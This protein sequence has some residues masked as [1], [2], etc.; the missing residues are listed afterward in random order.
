MHHTAATSSPTNQRWTVLSLVEWSTNHLIEHGFDEARLHAELLLAHV[1][2]CTRLQLYMNFD[3]PLTADELCM[4]R[5]LFKR[6]LTHEP[7]QYITG[8]TEFMGLPISVNSNVLIPRP[9]TEQLVEHAISI[10]NVMEKESVDVLDIGTGSGNIAIALAKLTSKAR[11]TS[12]EVSA[13]ALSLAQQNIERNAVKNVSL[14]L[15]DVFAEFLPDRIFDVMVSNPPY[16]SVTE[17]GTLDP[18]VRDFEPRLATTDG[19]DGYRFIRRICDVA[20]R[21]LHEGGSLLME[22]AHN[23]SGQAIT[24]AEMAGFANARVLADYSGHSRIIVVEK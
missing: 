16:I 22:I 24:I 5:S 19:A 6:R 7:L 10:V 17:H 8:E 1:L 3:R 9:E 11:V 18:E 2:E 14:L 15:G 23:Q 20:F 21:K 13:A 12:L 4:Y